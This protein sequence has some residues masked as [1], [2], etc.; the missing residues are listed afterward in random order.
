M[1]DVRLVIQKVG[2]IAPF[3]KPFSPLAGA[4]RHELAMPRRGHF[5]QA[6]IILGAYRNEDTCACA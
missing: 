5:T 6:D 3:C 1:R 4:K 2:D